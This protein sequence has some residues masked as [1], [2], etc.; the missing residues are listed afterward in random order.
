M[1]IILTIIVGALAAIAFACLATFEERVI[2]PRVYG[3]LR[4]WW[5]GL[6]S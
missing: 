3:A 5:K 1:L 2:N 4:K 6:K